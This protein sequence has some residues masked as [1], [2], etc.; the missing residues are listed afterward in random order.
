MAGSLSTYLITLLANEGVGGQHLTSHT[1]TLLSSIIE[2][3]S[4]TPDLINSRLAPLSHLLHYGW[5]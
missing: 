3:I 1:D 4:G 5:R 2:E